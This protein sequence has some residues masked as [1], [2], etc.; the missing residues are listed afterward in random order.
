MIIAGDCLYTDYLDEDRII[1]N[2]EELKGVVDYFRCKIFGGGTRPDRYI[3]GIG[4]NGIETLSY[5]DKEIIPCGTE[6]QT[7]SQYKMCDTLSYHW[8]GARNSQNYGFLNE[9]SCSKKDVMIKR[10]ASIT[11][12]ETIGLFDIMKHINNKEVY[13]IER[14]INTFDRLD[15][16]R[17]SPDLKGV[18]RIK[19]ERPDIFDR[20]IIDCSHSVGRKEYVADTYKAFKA[21]GIKHFMFECTIDGFSKT[22]YRHMLSAKELKELLK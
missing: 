16:S 20:L 22:D 6:I 1:H 19:H 17:W 15:D 18:I 2:A 3:A 5:I 10:G 7:L 21:I 13:I 8:I 9:I 14:G 4:I 11:I 12:D